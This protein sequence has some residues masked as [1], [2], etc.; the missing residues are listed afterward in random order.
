MT[1]STLPSHTQ[2]LDLLKCMRPNQWTKNAIVLAAFFFA[3]F[4]KQQ[5]Q[6]PLLQSLLIVIPAMVLFCLASS[7]IYII[8]DLR[9]IE[10]D[11][12]HVQKRHRPIAAGKVQQKR[13]ILLSAILLL[14]ALAGAWV[15]K[16]AFWIVL[17]CYVLLQFAYTFTLKHIALV[18]VFV[19]A[20]GFL[21]RAIAG[22]VALDIHISK[23]LLLC[24]FLLALFLALCKRRHE[25]LL[26]M[27]EGDVASR[28]SLDQYD[29]VLLD[30]LIAITAAS[31]V[32]CYAIYTLW[33][34]TVSKF[35]TDRLSFT[36]PIV[37]FGVFRY[38]DLAYRHEKG[39]RPEKVLLTDLPLILTLFLYGVSVIAIFALR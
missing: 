9:D 18:D 35:G 3:F 12:A 10:S 30:I 16:P 28:P 24:T 20:L 5:E 7:G 21:L 38:L 15:L 17:L 22:A 11:R 36:I 37:I 25:K 23:W 33:P 2:P 13:A 14:V 26:V 19:I 1:P 6:I 39:E 8:N 27:V 31:T 32:V 34:E 29:R 4:D